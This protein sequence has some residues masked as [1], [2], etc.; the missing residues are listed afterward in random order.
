MIEPICLNLNTQFNHSFNAARQYFLDT[1]A[2]LGTTAENNPTYSHS[3]ILHP[4]LGPEQEPLATDIVWLG[5]KNSRQVLVVISGTHGIEGYAGSAIQSFLLNQ[6]VST[7]LNLPD[8]MA[9][10]F[11][12]A[13]NPWGMAWHRR[14]DEQG[15]DLNRNFIDF[16]QP[17]PE[18]R[19]YEKIRPWMFEAN[20]L[21]RQQALNLQASE[22]GQRCFEQAL[23]GGQ[24]QD[25]L[26]PF[27]GGQQSSF[28]RQTIET[29]M[30][31]FQLATKELLVLDLHTGLGPWAYGELI[32]D[33]PLDSPQEHFAQTLFGAAINVPA[34]GTST[35]VPKHGLLDYAWHAIM[36][37]QHQR[38]CFLT[39]EFGTYSTSD[40]F[41]TLIDEHIL[42]A[43]SHNKHSTAAQQL[44][45]QHSRKPMLDHFY[46]QDRHWQ[47]ALLFKA[48]QVSE[49]ILSQWKP[50]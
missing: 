28:G 32:C 1:L 6:F 15:I 42:W 48:K 40:L 34:R 25:P 20:H 50:C 23:S 39:L 12:H 47:Q 29:V 5:P 46:P 36:T 35:S 44:T 37:A 49:Q 22:L 7:Q 2:K 10:L 27:F 8:N 31:E 11:I 14:C 19:H 9:L 41:N 24:Y 43:N 33:H 17:L 13:L 16:S 45:H 21:L 4:Q 30:T 18:H 26:A 3:T 38:S